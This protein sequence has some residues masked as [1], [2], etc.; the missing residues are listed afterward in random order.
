MFPNEEN[1]REFVVRSFQ[2]IVKVNFTNW[3]ESNKSKFGTSE[4][5]RATEMINIQINIM[6]YSFPLW[7][8]IICVM[9]ESKTPKT[10]MEFKV[11]KCNM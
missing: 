2:I 1:L 6:D 4:M 7:F 8:F 5:K 10:V 3:K 9:T 11:H